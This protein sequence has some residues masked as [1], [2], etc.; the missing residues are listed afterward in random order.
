[1]LSPHLQGYERKKAIDAALHILLGGLAFYQKKRGIVI[2]E[3]LGENFELALVDGFSQHDEFKALGA[4][5]FAR[6]AV[7]PFVGS[8]SVGP[9]RATADGFKRR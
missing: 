2:V 1:M 6:A 8:L 7:S 4:T 3:R 9:E 5:L